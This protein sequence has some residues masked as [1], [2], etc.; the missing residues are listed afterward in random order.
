[1]LEVFGGNEDDRCIRHTAKVASVKLC[2]GTRLSS[3]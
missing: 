2:H 3:D 1:M